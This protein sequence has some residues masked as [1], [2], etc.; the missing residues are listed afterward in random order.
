MEF[1]VKRFA[2]NVLLLHLML[3]VAVLGVVLLA[4]RAIHQGARE[5]AQQHAERRQRMLA[6]QT[7]RGI[8]AYYQ[9]ILSDLN[10]VPKPEDSQ[11]EKDRLGT[12]MREISRDITIPL[13]PQLGPATQPA[14]QSQ[15]QQP[16]QQQAPSG[17]S[18]QPWRDR[19]N[20]PGGPGGGPGNGPNAN[21]PQGR[22]GAARAMVMGQVLGRQLEDRVT[23]LFMVVRH[24]DLQ[25]P[26]P[27]KPAKGEAAT[28]PA[29]QPALP[30]PVLTIREVVAKPEGRA[31]PTPEQLV[32]RYHDWLASITVPP[33]PPQAGATTRPVPQQAVSRFE[34]FDGRGYNL[35]ALPV[36]NGTAVFVAAV[37]VSNIAEQYLSVLNADETTEVLLVNDQLTVMAGSRPSV[38]GANIVEA[39][40]PDL[41]AALEAAK[42]AGFRGSRVVPHPFAIAGQNYDPALL[43]TEPIEVAGRRWFIVVG[44]P[45]AEVD[46]VVAK[47]F[48]PLFVWAV[49]VVVAVTGILVSTSWTMI[50][51][52]A[53]LERVRM[54]AMRKEL[55]RARQ[56][57]QAWLPRESPACR[58]VEVAAVNF[59]ANHISGDF[60]NWFELRDGRIAVVIGDVTGHGMSAAFLMATTQ[61]L[62]RTTMQRLTDPA[63]A[64]EH[65][66][67]QLCTLIFN[68]QFV[69]LQVLV[70]DPETGLA[71][72]SSAG[73]P[74]PLMAG[75]DGRIAAVQADSG[76]VLGVDEDVRY[77]TFPVEV[78]PGGT[79]LL[80]TDG[81]A[82]VQ[83]P[84]G[85]RLTMDGLSRIC[86]ARPSNGHARTGSAQ[87]M[88]DTVVAGVNHFRGSRELGDD[89]TLVAVHF[90]GPALTPREPSFAAAEV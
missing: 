9:S 8:E 30:K 89:L 85:K 14:T 87:T 6:T 11:A 64:L 78:P 34:L 12:F 23:H 47:V 58:S 43:A 19:R 81:A 59:P 52:R 5:Q 66:N 80:Y 3:L 50:R 39:G 22:P 32:E 10:F 49:V 42:R 76:L 31:G 55:D 37:G 51:G 21:R 65:V 83:A 29:S 82:D 40:D 15:Q 75:P 86:P 41:R 13:L 27:P 36:N 20:G 24:P 70:I 25:P 28:R 69:T 54:E 63:E 7:A 57:Q 68:G 67:Q 53:R 16:P 44:S 79:L 88:I 73:H 45:L 61:L 90:N 46:A 56:I 74:P 60:Y 84:N 18:T 26:K 17:P 72:I 62:V 2:R 1:A 77:E 4:A 48:G 33:G 38:T 35:V 71:E